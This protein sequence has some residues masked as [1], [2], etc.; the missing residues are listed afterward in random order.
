[1]AMTQYSICTMLGQR[2]RRWPNIVQMIYKWFV[3]TGKAL[4][5]FFVRFNILM[6]DLHASLIFCILSFFIITFIIYVCFK[7]RFTHVTVVV[8]VLIGYLLQTL[9]RC[10][11]RIGSMFPASRLV[12]P[13]FV[14]NGDDRRNGNI[15]ET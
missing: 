11:I 8:L 5:T 4:C 14:V 1:M 7:F 9:P 12:L 15:I 3:F 6:L 10:W 2:Q 13:R